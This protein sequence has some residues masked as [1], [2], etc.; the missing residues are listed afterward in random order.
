[1][2]HDLQISN[3]RKKIF[4]DLDT[5]KIKIKLQ[6]SFI[7]STPDH[8]SSASLSAAG[9]RT[10]RQQSLWSLWLWQASRTG[11]YP[12][13]IL[14]LSFKRDA[15]GPRMIYS[16]I[17]IYHYHFMG[18]ACYLGRDQGAQLIEYQR[19]AR[20]IALQCFTL[21]LDETCAHISSDARHYSWILKKKH[22]VQNILGGGIS[23]FG[24][25]TL[26]IKDWL[27][28]ELRSVMRC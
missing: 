22:F 8:T 11:E 1:M 2:K 4:A 14:E 18:R 19:T 17:I 26:S 13:M 15:W 28:Q 21:D 3:L 9:G 27:R 23:L 12:E 10:C 24:E 20:M 16:N 6:K 25:I 7:T 5:F